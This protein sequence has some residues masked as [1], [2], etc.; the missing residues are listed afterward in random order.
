MHPEIAWELAAQ[1]RH[2]MLRQAEAARLGKLARRLARAVA[3]CHRAQRRVAILRASTDR[4]L[5]C[6]D[7]PPVDYGEFLARASGP[8]L[9]EP[10]ASGRARGQ[11]VR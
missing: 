2:D 10:A 3:D 6:P 1:R 9:R 5:P 4:Q 7:Q 8:L 11:S